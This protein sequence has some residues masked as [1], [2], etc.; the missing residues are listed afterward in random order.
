MRAFAPDSHRENKSREETQV[1]C[2]NVLIFKRW[3]RATS[4]TRT[5]CRLLR[6]HDTLRRLGLT[7]KIFPVTELTT[8]RP[9]RIAPKNSNNPASTSACLCYMT[10]TSE[11]RGE[12]VFR[13]HSVTGAKRAGGRSNS[14]QLSFP[15]PTRRFCIPVGGIP[16]AERLSPLPKQ[17]APATTAEDV[18]KGRGT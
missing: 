18:R 5:R 10:K 4:A 13:L 2:R 16:L 15:S 3:I 14:R 11:K 1:T 12:H 7:L 6:V 17:S 8:C 9:S